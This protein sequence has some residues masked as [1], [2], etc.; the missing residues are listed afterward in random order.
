MLGPLRKTDPL[1]A[2]KGPRQEGLFVLITLLP[3][4]CGEADFVR[5][6]FIIGRTF[7]S[8]YELLENQTWKNLLTFWL[9]L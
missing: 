6:F 9:V 5:I 7:P 4:W 3:L 8:Y 2:R 1:L